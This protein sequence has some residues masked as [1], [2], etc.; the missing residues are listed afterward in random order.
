MRS[1]FVLLIICGVFGTGIFFYIRHAETDAKIGDD[2]EESLTATGR[3]I[4]SV[5]RSGSLFAD[6]DEAQKDL[7]DLP[8]VVMA[9]RAKVKSASPSIT[10]AEG[11]PPLFKGTHQIVYRVNK[12]I[13]FVVRVEYQKSTERFKFLGERN[14]ISASRKDQPDPSQPGLPAPLPGS[15]AAPLP[16][17][18]DPAVPP[19]V[20]VPLPVPAA[21]APGEKVSEQP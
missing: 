19:P 9:V 17:S 20:P 11:D 13:V 15:P 6:T 12:E 1:L 21:P 2:I 10:V 4:W 7:E 5:G 3:D 16:G 8:R 14:G 18:S